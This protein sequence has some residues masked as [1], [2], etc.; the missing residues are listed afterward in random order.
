[1]IPSNT[2]EEDVSVILILWLVEIFRVIN[3]YKDIQLV[4]DEERH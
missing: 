1:M 2:N 3:W 4:D